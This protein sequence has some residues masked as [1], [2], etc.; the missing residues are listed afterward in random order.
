M[1]LDDFGAKYANMSLLSTLNF[2]ELK[3]DK[4]T[5]DTLVNNDKCQTIFII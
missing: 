4:S 2:D 3:I 5:I 1:S